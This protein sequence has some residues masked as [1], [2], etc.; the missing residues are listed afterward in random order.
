MDS[1][2][3]VLRS[4]VGASQ[5]VQ[6]ATALY[7]TTT[8]GIRQVRQH[9]L[10]RLEFEF[11]TITN[12]SRVILEALD[13]PS[14][15]RHYMLDDRLVDWLSGAE[16]ETCLD[17]LRE[18]GKL[19]RIERE[20]G[21]VFSALTPARSSCEEDEIHAAIVFFQARKAHFHFLLTT[22]IW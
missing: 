15:C 14:L 7:S 19:L 6:N 18:M 9:S 13:T 3:R 12:A 17:T 8:G 11:Q 21:Q 4:I 22:D 1:A 20:P 2:K 10:V 5:Q 16:P